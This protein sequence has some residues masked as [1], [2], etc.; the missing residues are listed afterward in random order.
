MVTIKQVRC[1]WG[2]SEF[3]HRT[4]R[5]KL[6]DFLW[7]YLNYE[8]RCY[9]T[10]TGK[11]WTDS[12]SPSYPSPCKILEKF[13]CQPSIAMTEDGPVILS[14]RGHSEHSTDMYLH[15]PESPTGAIYTPNCNSFAPV[16]IRSRTNR[17]FKVSM[18][19]T[20]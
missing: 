2:C 4:N 6:K 11:H 16:A 17:N 10:P 3:L 15:V 1:P 8:M 13:V 19:E 20:A 5:L 12:I 14:C 7:Y 18:L 9:Q